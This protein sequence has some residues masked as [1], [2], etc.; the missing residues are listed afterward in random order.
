MKKLTFIITLALLLPPALRAQTQ[1]STAVATLSQEE[2]IE[3][4]RL[5]AEKA[6]QDYERIYQEG[7]EELA[8][9]DQRIRDLREESYRY[10]SLLR[11]ARQRVREISRRRNEINQNIRRLRKEGVA[12]EIIADERAELRIIQNELDDARRHTR[13]INDEATEVNRELGSELK[14]ASSI[15]RDIN[16][17][18]RNARQEQK[19]LDKSLKTSK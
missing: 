13:L 15:R 6:R 11:N 10:D 9:L 14:K 4:N 18:R 12:K 19:K 8:V 1:D 7:N 5:S 17:S 2:I 3:Q 16:R